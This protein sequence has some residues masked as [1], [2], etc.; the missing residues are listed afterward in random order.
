MKKNEQLRQI[1]AIIL[2]VV[3]IFFGVFGARKIITSKKPIVSVINNDVKTVLVDTVANTTIPISINLN[4]NI[5]ALRKVELYAEVQGVFLQSGNKNFKAGE[6]YNT[7]NTLISIDN[8]ELRASLISQKS[9]LYNQIASAIPDLTFDY[10][11]ALPKWQSYL[12][13]FDLNGSL[14]PL[15]NFESEKEKLFISAKNI[16][17]SYYNTKN[18]EE[19]L[20]K[21]TIKAPFNGVLTE[22]LINPGALVRAGQKLGTFIDPSVYELEVAV[23]KAYSDL[24]Q[25]GKKVKL[26]NI[27][28]SKSW[29][30][31]V[32]R[33]NAS[34]NQSTQSVN[35]YVS[36]LG[37]DLFEG[38][39]LE[40]LID[41]KSEE[42][43]FEIPR[44]LL[45]EN[46]KIFVLKDDSILELKEIVPVFF[47]DEKVVVKGLSNGTVV[48]RNVL[49]GAYSGI[50]V[51]VVNQ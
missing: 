48:L 14:K 45:V 5:Q 7:G 37:S 27:E 23:P 46:N 26:T 12:S 2:G 16:V 39:Y 51:K 33:I 24:L 8:T 19:R 31:T 4:G 21:H 20:S 49:P 47:Y 18:L 40:A 25:I 3:I 1:I 22:S 9:I 36:V 41:I 28:K 35:T 17:A 15:P 44:N 32:S 34:V 10:P 50:Q 42:N 38:M 30:G 29:T 6:K 11:D 43:A 13:S